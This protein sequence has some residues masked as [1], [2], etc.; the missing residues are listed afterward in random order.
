[1]ATNGQHDKIPSS[2]V[3]A[4]REI[5]RARE[6]IQS[7][8]VALRYEVASAT[9]WRQWVA[10]HPGLCLGAAFAVGLYLGIRDV[11]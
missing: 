5:A 1:M 2:P 7:S 11:D 10:R 8:V 9:D 6:Q 3:E 4:R